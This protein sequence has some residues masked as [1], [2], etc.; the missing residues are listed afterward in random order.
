MRTKQLGNLGENHLE[1]LCIGSNLSKSKP[2]QDEN[3][4]D[5]FIEFPQNRISA[6]HLDAQPAPIKFLCQ[7]KAT[8][9]F[10]SK[11]LS[12]K[13]SNWEHLARTP[14]PT[15][16][17][18][19]DYK[20]GYS[21]VNCYLCHFNS[22]RIGQTLKR[23]R[24]LECNGKINLHEHEMTLTAHDSEKFV[25][26]NPIDLKEK[27]IEY[28]GRN[29]SEY[30]ELKN[31]I[32][33]NLGYESNRYKFSFT[34]KEDLF[35]DA[36]LNNTS[37]QVDDVTISSVRFGIEIIDTFSFAGILTISP[38]P[39]GTCEIVATSKKGK[40][41]SSVLA[42]VIAPPAATISTKN[43]KIKAKTP[44]IK[45][46]ISSEDCKFDIKIDEKL[47]YNL[48]E[49]I[50]NLNF[51]ST[52]FYPDSRIDFRKDGK[53]FATL[54]PEGKFIRQNVVLRSLNMLISL[55]KFLDAC[56]YREDIDVSLEDIKKHGEEFKWITLFSSTS[57]HNLTAILGDRS[58]NIDRMRPIVASPVIFEKENFISILF[59]YWD[60]ITKVENGKITAKISSPKVWDSLV[61]KSFNSDIFRYTI[62][63]FEEFCRSEKDSVMFREV[64]LKL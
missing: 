59:C 47:E 38:E 11:S 24:E 32:L 22:E 16:V 56:N 26:E 42:Q 51:I 2:G 53:T 19:L 50:E 7:V 17:L 13:V 28:T 33:H 55:R 39:S 34:T 30:T 21:P 9:N 18:I 45:A 43:F 25:S 49:F 48:N 29:L 27:I 1:K 58:I 46:L 41:R 6:V 8:D 3:G 40:R 12:M 5:Y 60:S 37:I 10:E 31:N 64:T 4:W 44:I 61:T 54:Y 15:F 23:I 52:I 57:K 35:I 36:L 63:E 14:L 20:N 62:K